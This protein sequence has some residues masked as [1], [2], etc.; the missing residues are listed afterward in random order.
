MNLQ[1]RRNAV[2][3]KDSAML[4]AHFSIH[5]DFPPGSYDEWRALVEKDLRG[6]PFEKKLVTH[7][8]EGID[9]QPVYARQD[10][11]NAVDAEGFPGL[12]PFVR[13]ATPVGAAVTG[14]DL[15]QEHAHPDI[16]V[17]NRAVLDDVQ[18]GVTSLLLRFDRA[19]RQGFDPDH[20]AAAS[21]AA[22]DGLTIYCLHDLDTLL[23]EVPLEDIAVTL[24][25]GAGFVPAAAM[26]V[27]VWRGRGIPAEKARGAFNADPL[28]VLSGEGRLPDNVPN[29]MAAM[30]DLAHWTTE[31]YPR[32]TAVGVNTAVYHN[33][34]ATAA[35]DV[36]FGMATAAEYLRV[37][38]KAG[39]SV[40]TAARQILFRIN[41]G[42]HHFL[43]IAKL[44]AA[45]RLWSRMIEACGGSS[46]AG[47]MG[48]HARTGQRVLTR[49]DP[50]VNLLR[51]CAAVFAAGVGGADAITSVPFD[52]MAG[53][54]DDFSRRVARNT[55]WI[56]QEEAHLCQVV[57]PAGGSWFL[58]TLTDEVADKA[59]AIL[60]Q[61]ERQGGM[62]QA[63]ESGW[64]AAQIDSAFAPRA[65]DIAR[66]KAGITGVSEFPD[67]SEQPL[68]QSAPTLETLRK[69]AA[70]RMASRR[71]ESDALAAVSAGADAMPAAV[72]AASEGASVG[73][74][75]QA[76]GWQASP[77]TSVTPLPIRPFAE[78]F[79]QLRDAADAWHAEH[80]AR[81]RVFLAKMGPVSHH[82]ARASYAKNFFEA[83]G[84]E[85]IAPDGPREAD[86][87]GGELAASGSGIAVICSSDQLYPDIVKEAAPKLKAAGARTVILAGHPGTKEEIY[88]NAGVDGFIYIGCD[89]LDTLRGLLRDE[90]VLA[91]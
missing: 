9:I 75:A 51:N 76:L 12:P 54:P 13:G 56:L 45:R 24:D 17:S 78:P 58:E 70:D 7:T 60:Q 14:W 23:A 63:I 47:A 37:M 10:R 44:R 27:A 66:R 67:A 1:A 29:M 3:S 6:A 36:A 43:A 4:D 8:Y 25:A 31:T 64:V 71:R 53:L 19:A 80:G 72:D 22:R 48:V 40:D 38:S 42:T 41:V 85:V 33:A 34:G 61:I 77:A 46:T 39:M 68:A 28:A 86:A 49:R 26:L 89:V 59:W 69:S 74:L 62:T 15:R 21:L 91:R 90:G 81:P 35:Q 57:D 52:A 50:Y 82:T 87:A 16:G 73:Q 5:E 20:P 18:G 32:V 84:F 30:A 55:L 65:K 83:G 11:P 79:E 2:T 88:R